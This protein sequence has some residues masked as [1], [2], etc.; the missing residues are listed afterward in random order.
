MAHNIQSRDVQYGLEQAWH[1]L[2]VIPESGV[3]TKELA[4]PWSPIYKELYFSPDNS[5]AVQTIS[6]ETL[7]KFNKFNMANFHEL[8]KLLAGLNGVQAMTKHVEVLPVASDD[9]LPLGY[10]KAVNPETYTMEGPQQVWEFVE[11]V[12]KGT[13]F[14]V[15]SAGTVANRGKFFVSAQLTELNKIISADGKEHSLNFNAKGSL[16]KSLKKQLNASTTTIVCQNTLMLDFLAE[17]SLGSIRASLGLP[18]LF[19]GK[20]DK[21]KL[22]WTYRHSKN[23]AER[24]ETD[25][26]AMQEAVGYSAI[27]RATFDSLLAKPC[28]KDRAASIYAGMITRPLGKDKVWPEE[29][30]TRASNMVQEHVWAFERGDGNEGKSEMDLL[31]GWTQPRTRGYQESNKD[32]FGIFESSE[33]GV[34]GQSKSDFAELLTF[35]RDRVEELA[36]K[37]AA[38]LKTV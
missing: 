34:Y 8:R 17:H 21:M 4:F 2:T 22:G 11:S 3:I 32:K 38:L 7:E 18:E 6:A 15:I 12:L 27:V 1:K 31:S 13:D 25:K 23:M 19:Q 5:P 29:L 28:D 26:P 30:S 33:M 24:V 37:G 35:K 9:G 36:T 16:D 10:G 14:R 20:D